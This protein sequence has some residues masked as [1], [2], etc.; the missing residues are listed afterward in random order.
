[1]SASDKGAKFIAL[2]RSMDQGKTMPGSSHHRLAVMNPTSNHED[3][4]SVPGLAQWVQGSD[5][6]VICGVGCKPGLDPSLLWQRP[7]GAAPI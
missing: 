1:M 5:G 4:G 3:V 2:R 6:A 7:V